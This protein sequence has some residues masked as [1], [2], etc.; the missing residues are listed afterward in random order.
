MTLRLAV[1]LAADQW[2]L[3][4]PTP[5]HIIKDSN[6]DIDK[7]T[8]TLGPDPW[9]NDMHTPIHVGHLPWTTDAEI[10]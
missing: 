6:N 7:L 8:T 2:L 3:L 10:N 9:H 4:T 5:T 1:A